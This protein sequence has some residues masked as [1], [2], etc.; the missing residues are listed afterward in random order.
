[1]THA[2]LATGAVGAAAGS[3]TQIGSNITLP[4]GGPWLIHGIWSQVVMDT[5]VQSEA[6]NGNLIVSALSGDLNPDPATGK[7]PSNNVSAQSAASFGLVS[8]P[9]N[10]YPVNWLAAGKAVISLTYENLSGNATAPI[11][12]AGIIFGDSIPDKSPLVFSDGVGGTLTAAVEA[13]IGS[14]TLAEK[15][16]RIVG[17]MATAMKDGAIVADEGMLA[18]IRL[19]SSDV[20]FSPGQYP[21]GQAYNACDGTPAGGSGLA[22]NQFIPLDIPVIGGAIINIFGTLV[23]AVTNGLDVSVYIAYE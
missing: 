4:A 1:V 6:V 18:H 21:C 17:I 22:Q 11:A 8:S 20:K 5:A 14:I 15:A 13:S 3:K 2:Q 12:A 16:T 19:D 23:N 9:L 7:Y 10:I